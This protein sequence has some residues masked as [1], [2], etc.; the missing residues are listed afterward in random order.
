L[1]AIF[2]VVPLAMLFS[3]VPQLALALIA[4]QILAPFAFARLD[5]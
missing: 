1:A 4:L 5:R 2:L 3:V